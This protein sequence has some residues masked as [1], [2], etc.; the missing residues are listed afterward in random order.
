MAYVLFA[1]FLFCLSVMVHV[2]FCR[3]TSKAGLHARAYVLIAIFLTGV[4]AAGVYFVDPRMLDPRS[5]WGLPFKM[6]SG[7]IFVLL[8]P[9]YLSFYVLTQLMSPS[10]KILIALSRQG[11]LSYAGILASIEEEDFINT[12]LRDLCA[13][14]CVI[15]TG[16]RYALSASGQKIAMVLNI[17]QFILGRGIGG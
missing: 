14:G 2:F 15:Q 9:V 13:S 5:F 17:M 16:D 7:F 6:T 1:L 8:I 3:N 12:R 10:K 11:S 4:Y